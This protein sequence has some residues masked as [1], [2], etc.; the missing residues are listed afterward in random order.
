MSISKNDYEYQVHRP[1]PSLPDVPE[2]S[3]CLTVTGRRALFV[4]SPTQDL[5]LTR[6][7]GRR[8]Q[9]VTASAGRRTPEGGRWP[10]F[11]P[12]ARPT[13]PAS[14]RMPPVAGWIAPIL[15]ETENVH[16]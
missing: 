9:D 2:L 6:G 1:G 7:Q 16:F 4:L 8:L 12:P 5:R 3:P 10:D 11:E 13:A 15:V 14:T